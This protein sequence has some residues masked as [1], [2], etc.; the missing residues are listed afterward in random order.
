MGRSNGS[1]RVQPRS[2]GREKALGKNLIL[3]LFKWC[4]RVS[5]RILSLYHS[6]ALSSCIS[7][8][9]FPK[10]SDGEV[11]TIMYSCRLLLIITSNDYIV[12]KPFNLFLLLLLYLPLR[13]TTFSTCVEHWFSLLQWAIWVT[14]PIYVTF[15]Y[16]PKSSSILYCKAAYLSG[17]GPLL[18]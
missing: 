12:R 7:L 8:L 1:H 14:K 4:G 5:T 10:S 13:T 9:T 17:L 6:T 15:S 3:V 2:Q 11:G 18:C 16:R